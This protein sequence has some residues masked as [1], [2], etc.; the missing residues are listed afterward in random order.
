MPLRSQNP[1]T[2]EIYAD[3]E[4]L[5][6]V[7]IYHAI[8]EAAIA[9]N[10]RKNTSRE[11]KKT[12]THRLA[13]LLERDIDMHATNQTQEMG[14]IFSV[15]KKWLHS[16]VALIR[17]FADNAENI[18]KPQPFSTTDWLVGEYQYDPLGVIYGIAPR[19]FPYNQ[20]LRAAIPNILAGNTQI[21]KHASNVPRCALAI[22]KLFDD[23]WFPHGVYTNLFISWSQSELIIAHPCVAW[24]NVTGGETVGSIIWA[25]AG[26]YLKPSVLELGGNDAFIV[27]D[28]H[29]LD[30][31]VAAAVSCRLA[32]GWQKC[33]SSKRF[34]V[35]A[36][37]YESFCE[38]MSILLAQQK[39]GDPFDLTTNLWPLATTEI[40]HTVH[41]QVLKTCEQGA[42][43][44]TW[45][46]ILDEAKNLYAP[47]LLADIK[48]GMVAFEEEI[49]GP[50]ASVIKAH[51]IEDAIHLANTSPYWLS[52]VVYG[53]DIDQ[54][55]AVARRLEGGMIFINQPAWSKAS[56]PFGWVKK[57]WYGKENGPEW[58][59]AF[60]NKKVILF[61]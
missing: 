22:Q 6:D 43:C 50:V 40:L 56:L 49:F 30:A 28:T 3:F 8:E 35:P 20:L 57:S 41:K 54:C 42:R 38:K 17:R 10:T 11:T 27:L 34:I 4:P 29:N 24:V 12:L 18:L 33:N 37:L 1:Y 61:P 19:N 45:W 32:N 55:K 9:F 51:D 23:A 53:D 2:K 13:D 60:T 52:A 15:S 47:T 39:V 31:V 46:R 5:G 7:D 14:M 16:T 36:P 58:L 44:L 26:K 25:M 48:P 59:R 21:Y